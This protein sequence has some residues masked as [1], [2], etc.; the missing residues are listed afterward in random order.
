MLAEQSNQKIHHKLKILKKS[1]ELQKEQLLEEVF[2]AVSQAQLA[3]LEC[4]SHSSSNS[5]VNSIASSVQSLTLSCT[6]GLVCYLPKPKNWQNDFIDAPF[7]KRQSKLAVQINKDFSNSDNLTPKSN[8]KTDHKKEP[9]KYTCETVV[10]KSKTFSDDLQNFMGNKIHEKIAQ[11]IDN[12]I[13]ELVEGEDSSFPIQ[14]RTSVNF[15]LALQQ[16]VDLHN[17][18]PIPLI[19]F[20]IFYATALTTLKRDFGN[21]LSLIVGSVLYLINCR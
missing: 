8:L 12:F 3:N 5:S 18:P 17:L 1:S 15:I 11:S 21:P 7:D 19:R 14:T 9:S 13:D 16:E 10:D 2:K 4:K 20:K 6:Q